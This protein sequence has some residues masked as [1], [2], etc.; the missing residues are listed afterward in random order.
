MFKLAET[1]QKDHPLRTVIHNGLLNHMTQNGALHTYV[2]L[3]V[4]I[5]DRGL[6]IKA[7]ETTSSSETARNESLR[8]A[9]RRS[10]Q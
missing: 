5:K 9:G 8:A 7:P 10:R 4:R 2:M 6:E 3:A 1:L